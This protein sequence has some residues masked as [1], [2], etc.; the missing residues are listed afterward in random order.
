MTGI[1]IYRSG[2][3]SFERRGRVLGNAEVS[4]RFG[5]SQI[6]DVLK[7]MLVV[8]L[9]GGR[10]EGVGY[11]SRDPLQ[12][13][14]ASFA[15]DL[16]NNPSLFDLLKQLRG[17]RVELET[18]GGVIRGAVVGVESRPA[19]TQNGNSESRPF[20][21][22]M[23][24]DGAIKGVDLTGAQGFRIL[25]ERLAEEFRMALET[26]GERH[27]ENTKAVDLRFRGQGE[28]EVAVAYVQEAPIWKT[29]YRLVLPE[30]SEGVGKSGEALLQ[31]WA[32][33][34]NQTDEDWHDV[35]LSLVA[36]RP[37]SFTMDL[38]QPLYLSRPDVPVPVMANVGPQ[39][40]DG[41]R[42]ELDDAMGDASSIGL[43]QRAMKLA[44]P[45]PS[46]ASEA[47]DFASGVSVG[48]GVSSQAVADSVT[49]AAT[50]GRV[51]EV[52]EYRLDNPVTIERQRSAMLPILANSID[53]RRVSIFSYGNA[54]P[55]GQGASHPM[56]GVEITN[57]EHAPLMAGPISVFDGERYA[58]DAQ[59]DFVSGGEDRLL[60]YAVDLDI[61]VSSETDADTI[62]E[63]LRIVNGAFERTQLRRDRVTHTFD[64]N[65]ARRP[66][67]I[68][69]E[70]P[71]LGGWELVSSQKPVETTGSGYRFETVIDPSGEHELTVTQERVVRQTV[72]LT[73]YGLDTLVALSRQGKV[74]QGVI[75]AVRE[76]ARRRGL[77]EAS[78]QRVEIL[79][80]ERDAIAADQSRI[81]NNM[82]RLDRNGDLYKR[83]VRKLGDQET[84]LEDLVE[85]IADAQQ[86]ANDHREALAAYVSD[87]SVD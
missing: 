54:V 7:S 69:T 2:V 66:R 73:S 61:S 8:D 23:T 57:A 24:D 50:S 27:D 20:V 33:V 16:S 46:A 9:D 39:T 52:V 70:H 82:N 22:V 65:D 32:L 36:G 56:R 15:L 63:K 47:A 84:R 78:E 21:Q 35:Q 68:I 51:G 74:S 76:A 42:L 37:V 79:A 25:D 59:I 41:A 83:Y 31:G 17:A 85:E 3:A 45:M 12:R 6:N 4:M 18:I 81:R 19:T 1:T 48:R 49:S 67:T 10:V 43:R 86:L 30:P 60:S 40:Y 26:I 80:K 5:A 77:V 13:R 75:D 72:G 62:V 14:L 64:S 87:L 55:A 71:K 29:S 28:R 53:A 38:Y 44:A 11:E 58:G 34:E